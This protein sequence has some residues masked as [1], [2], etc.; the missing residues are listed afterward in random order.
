[1]P[2]PARASN[3][4]RIGPDLSLYGVAIHQAIATA[5]LARMREMAKL[6]QEWLAEHGDLGAALET[7]KAEI[8]RRE[9]A[10]S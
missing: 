7:L 8:A 2:A 1:M 9:A 10:G 5:N 4:N 6:A 3:F